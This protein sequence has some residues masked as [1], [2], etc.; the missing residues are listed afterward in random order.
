M[1]DEKTFEEKMDGELIVA[2]D[3]KWDKAASFFSFRAIITFS[4][5]LITAFFY[6]ETKS[7]IVK[8]PTMESV[9]LAKLV[10]TELKS[11]AGFFGTLATIAFTKWVFIDKND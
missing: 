7:L 5:V 2:K 9:E 10:L 3:S 4:V 8:N 6:Y 11:A 1:A